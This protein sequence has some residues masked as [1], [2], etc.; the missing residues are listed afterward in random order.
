[1]HPTL[2]TKG[3]PRLFFIARSDT[4][5]N[6]CFHLLKEMRSQRREKIGSEAGKPI[7][8]DE[9]DDNISDHAYDCARYFI[10]S[11]PAVA[12]GVTP[13]LNPRSFKAVREGYLKFKRKGG[14]KQMA[15]KRRQETRHGENI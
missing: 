12:H 8:S 4:H 3:S 11:R 5:P 1:V 14:F 6:G 15:E 13:G 7:F 9:R 2:K 10:A